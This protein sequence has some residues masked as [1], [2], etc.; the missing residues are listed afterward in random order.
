MA[1]VMCNGIDISI[2]AIVTRTNSW[3]TYNDL[4]QQAWHEFGAKSANSP[5]KGNT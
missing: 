4:H 3:A 1:N 5:T 2:T